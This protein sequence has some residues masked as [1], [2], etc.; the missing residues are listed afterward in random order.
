MMTGIRKGNS[1]ILCFGERSAMSRQ[2][3]AERNKNV[4][5]GQNGGI[6]IFDINMVTTCSRIPTTCG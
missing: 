3:E 2:D 5:T 6:L 1:D 4:S